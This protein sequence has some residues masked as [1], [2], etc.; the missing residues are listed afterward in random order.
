MKGGALPAATMLND[1]E[2]LRKAERASLLQEPG[3][4]T[5]RLPRPLFVP[6]KNAWERRYNREDEH[7]GVRS[8][9]SNQGSSSSS[10]EGEVDAQVRP[11]TALLSD[12]AGAFPDSTITTGKAARQGRISDYTETLSLPF[13]RVSNDCKAAI[14]SPLASLAAKRIGSDGEKTRPRRTP[15]TT[16]YKKR[17]TKARQDPRSRQP[18][19]AAHRPQ[20]P[21]QL[22]GAAHPDSPAYGDVQLPVLRIPEGRRRGLDEMMD[23]AFQTDVSMPLSPQ[24]KTATKGVQLAKCEMHESNADIPALDD[25][26]APTL[27]G[28]T[29]Q[30][31]WTRVPERATIDFEMTKEK[32]GCDVGEYQGSLGMISQ[33]VRRTKR[34]QREDWR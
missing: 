28:G 30:G 3:Q 23:S 15:F 26:F 19:L 2:F 17:N 33:F 27:A 21:S 22:V 31:S 14:Q 6:G 9:A 5:Y 20:Q 7:D 1:P 34:R 32:E 18:P 8:S 24:D 16:P 29:V 10:Q 25:R 11:N 13:A 12:G 4:P